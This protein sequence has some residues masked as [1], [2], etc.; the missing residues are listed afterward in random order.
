[1]WVKGE[2]AVSRAPPTV[3]HLTK[4]LLGDSATDCLGRF[5]QLR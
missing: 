5:T 4:V 1:M 2:A 3:A